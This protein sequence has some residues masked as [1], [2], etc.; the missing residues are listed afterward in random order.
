MEIAQNLKAFETLDEDFN[1]DK[2]NIPSMDS[3]IRAN[4]QMKP[5]SQIN[6]NE[7]KMP[8]KHDS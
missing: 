1:A 6:M 2:H 7:L 8:N 4:D 3:A 5:F